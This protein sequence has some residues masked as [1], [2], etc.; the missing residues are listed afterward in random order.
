MDPTIDLLQGELERLF[1]LEQLIHLSAHALAIPADE[2]GGASSKGAFARSLV[3]R[4]AKDDALQ[5]LADAIV[6]S[7]PGADARL[8]DLSHGAN[9]ELSPGT[10][11]GNL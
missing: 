2:L 11:V 6:L 1:E 3:T 9:G 7:A 10:Q 4:C 8:K 5:A